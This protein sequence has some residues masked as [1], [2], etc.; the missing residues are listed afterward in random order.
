MGYQGLEMGEEHESGA[1][2]KGKRLDLSVAQVAGSALAAAIAA[3]L[4]GRLGLYGTI[5]GAGVVSVLATTGGSIFQHLFRRTG[6]H[7]KEASLTTRPKPRRASRADG[8]AHQDPTTVLP[9]FDR[10]GVADPVTS[11]AA[12][13]P[14]KRDERDPWFV[15][16]D[17]TRLLPP[18]SAGRVR[19]AGTD[20]DDATRV[21]GR[22]PASRA[23]I[24]AQDETRAM[25]R[26]DGGFGGAEDLTRPLRRS[27]VPGWQPGSEE[28][29]TATYGT[30]WRG[31][32]RPALA[33]LAVFVLAMGV[34]T[35]IELITGHTPDGKK[36]TTVGRVT[37]PG[38][39]NDHRSTPSGTPSTDGS[40][41]DGGSGTDTGHPSHGATTPPATQVPGNGTKG[42]TSPGSGDTGD[43]KDPSTTPPADGG[44]VSPPPATG[45]PSGTP[46]TGDG[47]GSG[48]GDA[49]G[50]QGQTGRPP[51]DDQK[52]P[53]P[54]AS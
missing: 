29:S 16:P 20:P 33:A 36:G 10:R 48:T 43:K 32:K 13:D 12:R 42:T 21:L 18:H 27:G 30:R 54:G 41:G 26:A 49:N 44:K 46:G 25:G 14:Q 28:E 51:Q 22:V 31:W 3:F 8:P 2:H 6:E 19:P 35:G 17:R 52:A 5:I 38:G 40:T 24:G 37:N 1:K 47:T 53:N 23:P 15:D 7:I 11:V 34:V 4:T 50:D 45:H 9:A 39:H